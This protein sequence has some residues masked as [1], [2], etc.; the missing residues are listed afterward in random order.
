MKL[1]TFHYAQI[2]T[3]PP[4]KCFVF[5]V[6]SFFIAVESYYLVHAILSQIVEFLLTKLIFLDIFFLLYFHP[7]LTFCLYWREEKRGWSL[8]K[9]PFVEDCH[10]SI[11]L[12]VFWRLRLQ[13]CLYLNWHQV[14]LAQKF[15]LRSVLNNQRYLLSMWLPETMDKS[16]VKQEISN[17]TFGGNLG[18]LKN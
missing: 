16:W 5:L 14:H 15:F 3:S 2:E 10:Y 12:I 8:F 1:T 17:K 18:T 6:I 11:C 9:V 7:Y 13:S 4:I